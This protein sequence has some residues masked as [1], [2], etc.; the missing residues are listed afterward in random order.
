M[1]L[2]Y[3]YVE[4]RNSSNVSITTS[5]LYFQHVL[6]KNACDKPIFT[7]N[8][9]NDKN[10]RSSLYLKANGYDYIPIYLKVGQ[11]NKNTFLWL[12]V[13]RL[14]DHQTDFNEDY[15][16]LSLNTY[17]SYLISKSIVIWCR[18]SLGSICSHGGVWKLI[19]FY[20]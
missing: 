18:C 4:T 14:R 12:W 10:A 1:F 19:K 9:V 13:S 7:Q 8:C 17:S 6:Y 3:R 20:C 11:I 15:T 5:L 2:V 16:S